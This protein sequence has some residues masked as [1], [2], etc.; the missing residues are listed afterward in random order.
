MPGV[1]S[2][3]TSVTHVNYM[4]ICLMAKT[5]LELNAQEKTITVSEDNNLSVQFGLGEDG[6]LCIT[7]RSTDICNTIYL[8][9]PMA[10]QLLMWISE[11]R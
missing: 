8:D 4:R 10:D 6:T 1:L 5:T 7:S 9:K 11:N 2:A 3:T